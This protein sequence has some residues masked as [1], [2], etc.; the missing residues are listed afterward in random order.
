MKTNKDGGMDWLGF[1]W[2]IKQISLHENNLMCPIC[3]ELLSS[4]MTF[5]ICSH[6]F[7]SLCIRRALEYRTSC[8]IC[9]AAVSTSSMYNNHLVDRIIQTYVAMVPVLID[10][11]NNRNNNVNVFNEQSFHSVENIANKEQPAIESISK[12]RKRIEES[13]IANISI[14]NQK[15]E[16]SKTIHCPSCNLLFNDEEIAT[17]INTCIDQNLA[18]DYQ[19]I[20][21]KANNNHSNGTIQNVKRIVPPVYALMSLK[22]LKDSL[23][24]FGLSDKGERE[25]LIWRHKE[26]VLQFNSNLDSLNPKPIEHIIELVKR[27]EQIIKQATKSSQEK[28]KSQ[29]SIIS[30]LSSQKASNK[31]ECSKKKSSNAYSALIEEVKTR[32]KPKETQIPM[33]TMNTE[34]KKSCIEKIPAVMES[35]SDSIPIALPESSDNSELKHYTTFLDTGTQKRKRLRISNARKSSAIDSDANKMLK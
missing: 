33:L 25:D 35:K 8:P 29:K 20:S 18:Q 23:R 1:T 17:H 22:N 16:A 3:H 26:Y 6:T 34:E 2:P 14:E 24:K 32:L 9:N 19:P 4:A 13:N 31:G 15:D 27:N 28:N 30:M 5:S 11:C 12:K 21:F 7:C 10:L